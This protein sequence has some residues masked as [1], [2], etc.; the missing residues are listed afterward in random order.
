META[1]AW[2]AGWLAAGAAAGI[3]DRP[4]Q[5]GA[6][7]H[8]HCHAVAVAVAVAAAVLVCLMRSR[9][10]G[11]AATDADTDD[12]GQPDDGSEA[13]DGGEGGRR[14]VNVDITMLIKRKYAQSDTRSFILLLV[15]G[16]LAPLLLGVFWTLGATGHLL[17]AWK[18]GQKVAGLLPPPPD[19]SE[20]DVEHLWDALEDTH[21]AA[22]FRFASERQIVAA[23]MAL[24]R[25]GRELRAKTACKIGL[26]VGHAA[27]AMAL[28][29]GETSLVLL[30]VGSTAAAGDG[31]SSGG[32]SDH[33]LPLHV[34]QIEQKFL[35][36][37]LGPTSGDRLRIARG[38]TTNEAVAAYHK[39]RALSAFSWQRLP[40]LSCD[41]LQISGGERTTREYSMDLATMHGLHKPPRGQAATPRQ[42]YVMIVFDDSCQ[43]EGCSP[44]EQAWGKALTLGLVTADPEGCSSEAHDRREVHVHKGA[45]GERTHSKRIEGARR[46][47]WC[48]GWLSY[49][50]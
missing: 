13:L 38:R 2:L 11:A 1:L 7:R 9:L 24:W 25:R 29:T 47:G 27:V 31:V 43:E 16:F 42:H 14:K 10:P 35:R 26:D 32:S 30:D 48:T 50:S 36:T 39:A 33:R 6:H 15:A 21:L 41:I 22:S 23:D 37:H 19:A 46:R 45:N 40:S 12:D 28:A 18:Y 20:E 4:A 49:E 8:L 34:L 17:D 3:V 44:A 5:Y